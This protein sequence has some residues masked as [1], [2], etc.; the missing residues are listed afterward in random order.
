MV[1][2][3]HERKTLRALLST[4]SSDCPSAKNMISSRHS[5]AFYILWLCGHRFPHRCECRQLFVACL[6]HQGHSIKNK[7]IQKIPSSSTFDCRSYFRDYSPVHPQ[8][9][10]T[11]AIHPILNLSW[12]CERSTD[13]GHVRNNTH[14]SASYDTTIATTLVHKLHST[15]LDSES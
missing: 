2:C 9:Y 15:P 3:Q 11:S 7:D 1:S 14:C 12:Q 5:V 8:S 4:R 10:S 13:M 6:I